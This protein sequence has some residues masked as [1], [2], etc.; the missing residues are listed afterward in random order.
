MDRSRNQYGWIIE[1]IYAV[2]QS[3]NLYTHT[4]LFHRNSYLESSPKTTSGMSPF[5]KRP[6]ELGSRE[7]VSLHVRVVIQNVNSNIRVFQ[8]HSHSLPKGYICT[9]RAV[10]TI[11]QIVT[12]NIGDAPFALSISVPQKYPTTI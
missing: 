4:H 10:R 12:T 3:Q 1:A 11:K 6:N 9:V 2:C 8:G 5:I 7:I